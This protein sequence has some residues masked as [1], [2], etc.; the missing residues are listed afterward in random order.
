MNFFISVLKHHVQTYIFNNF[1]YPDGYT[2]KS[3]LMEYK[4][5]IKNENETAR[6]SIGLFSCMVY[7]L[8]HL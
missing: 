5:E 1:G 4:A 6:H 2:T 3:T 7:F 8:V